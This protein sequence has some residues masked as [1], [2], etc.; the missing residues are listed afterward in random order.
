MQIP[1]SEIIEFHRM[2]TTAH[3]DTLNY[4]AGLLGYCFPDHDRDKHTEPYRTGYAY[5][6]YAKHHPHCHISAAQ[7]ELFDI[8]HDEHH[9]MQPHHIE[10]YESVTDIPKIVLIE[11][12]CDWH[13][14]NFES[15]LL[16]EHPEF[17]SVTIWFDK[18]MGALPWT[19]PQR[20]FITQTIQDIEHR[21]AH[22]DIMKIW[23]K[24]A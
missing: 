8:A 6:N 9:R 1:I 19:G 21:Q 7:R 22:D 3:I 18:C 16:N 20:E 5:V 23:A 14:A 24:L 2:R 15:R 12:I 17:P 10:H 11:M 13:S 4:F